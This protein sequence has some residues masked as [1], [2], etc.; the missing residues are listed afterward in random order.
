VAGWDGNWSPEGWDPEGWSPPAPD[1]VAPDFPRLVCRIRPR[2]IFTSPYLARC[3]VLTVSESGDYLFPDVYVNPGKGLQVELDLYDMCAAKWLP[4]RDF[5]STQRVLPRTP[6][7]FE[8]EA[9]TGGRT[10]GRE[11]KWPTTL[12]GTVKDGSV[13]WTARAVTTATTFELTGLEKSSD[14]G[15]TIS[16][17]AVSNRCR[18][19]ATYAGLAEGEEATAVFTFTLNGQARAGRQKVI[20]ITH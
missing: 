10:T 9:T 17:E 19:L 2:W 3:R 7:G 12:D 1:Q 11:P 5:T 18:I 20:G 15:L 6:T 13:T 14:G 16:G 4:N 8:Y